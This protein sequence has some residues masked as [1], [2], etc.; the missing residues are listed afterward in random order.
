MTVKG[1]TM[2]MGVARLSLDIEEERLVQASSQTRETK[3]LEGLVDSVRGVTT[4]ISVK[5][6]RRKISHPERN[7]HRLMDCVLAV[8]SLDT[9]QRRVPKGKFVRFVRDYIQHPFTGI[10]KG[11]KEMK[12]AEAA[13]VTLATIL[14]S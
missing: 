1:Q 5:N 6:S 10:P 7:T 12:E 3:L 11:K 14:D 2:M 8:L 4:W 9:C 13:T